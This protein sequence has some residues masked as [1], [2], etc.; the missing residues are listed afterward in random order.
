LRWTARQSVIEMLHMSD[1]HFRERYLRSV[2]TYEGPQLFLD[3]GQDGRFSSALDIQKPY[4]VWTGL[5]RLEQERRAVGRHGRQ[6][7]DGRT[8]R[9]SLRV[10]GRPS[11][12]CRHG[13]TPYAR[14]VDLIDKKDTMVIRGEGLALHPLTRRGPQRIRYC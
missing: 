13:K 12:V 11:F 5:V 1:P 14:G 7:F 9:P 8:L 10:S 2:R 3:A 6:E 4:I